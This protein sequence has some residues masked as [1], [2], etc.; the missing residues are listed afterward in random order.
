MPIYEQQMEI[1]TFGLFH[2]GKDGPVIDFVSLNLLKGKL[3]CSNMKEE[4]SSHVI[5]Q[6][7]KMFV[8]V[9]IPQS[10]QIR[11]SLFFFTY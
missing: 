11:T 10:N 2:H 1:R 7:S 3:N 5:E 8:G 4:Q 6:T 9:I